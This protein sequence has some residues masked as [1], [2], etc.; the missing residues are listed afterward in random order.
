MKTIRRSS[1]RGETNYFL[2]KK[3]NV[4]SLKEDQNNL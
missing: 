2:K 4:D 1:N 3:T